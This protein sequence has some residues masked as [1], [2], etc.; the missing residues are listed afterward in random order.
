ME[1]QR[2][3]SFKDETWTLQKETYEE[4]FARFAAAKLKLHGDPK[5]IEMEPMDRARWEKFTGSDKL[6]LSF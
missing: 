2:G 4:Y 3:R 5:A 6:V 1:R